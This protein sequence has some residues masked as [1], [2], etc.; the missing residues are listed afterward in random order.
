MDTFSE[1]HTAVCATGT[2]VLA[3]GAPNT[4]KELTKTYAHT[5]VET[6]NKLTTSQARYLTTVHAAG[7]GRLVDL[8]EAWNQSAGATHE[9]TSGLLDLPANND[10][11]PVVL[12][13]QA[14][15]QT[16]TKKQKS[17]K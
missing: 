9:S 6:G 7:A 11:R 13:S 17:R 3:L 5:L 1:M 2:N 15:A 14:D 12:P 4:V 16:T 10:V 8:N